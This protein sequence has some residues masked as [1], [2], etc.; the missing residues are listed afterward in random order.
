[1]KNAELDAD[2]KIVE[3][4][5]INPQYTNSQQTGKKN[6]TFSHYITELCTNSHSIWKATKDL[7][8]R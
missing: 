5:K 7:K 6:E 4:P 1:M 2:G 8:D 3:I